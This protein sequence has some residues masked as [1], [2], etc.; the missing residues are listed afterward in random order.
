[1]EYIVTLILCYS[2][3][4]PVKNRHLIRSF[5][6]P[7]VMVATLPVIFSCKR[8]P[9]PDFSFTPTENPEAGDTISF[10]NQS[11]DADSYEWQFGDGSSSNLADPLYIYDQAGIYEV[12]LTA[13]NE[14][15]SQAKT[16]SITINE[17]TILGFVV[18]DSTKTI[19]LEE[20]EVSLYDNLHDYENFG[21]TPYVGYT[22]SNGIVAFGNLEPVVYY[23]WIYRL[24]QEGFW[25]AFGSTD[26]LTQ[27]EITFYEVLCNWY[28]YPAKKSVSAENILQK[29]AA[30]TSRSDC[31]KR[32]R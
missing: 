29:M 32:I 2:K 12:T 7:W 19:L 9:E 14:A 25:G 1:M 30:G 8:L 28:E 22:D 21:E 11:V 27:N 26:A 16:Q 15:G 10:I 31:L 4:K 23:I 18:Y 17:P 20:A 24:E 3:S 5:R 13:E 6:F